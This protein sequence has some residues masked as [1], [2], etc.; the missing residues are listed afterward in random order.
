[1]DNMLTFFE[2]LSCFTSKCLHNNLLQ[3]KLKKRKIH[4]PP[5]MFVCLDTAC[6][7]QHSRQRFKMPPLIQMLSS[8]ECLRNN[9][10][11]LLCEIRE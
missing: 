1:M 2:I 11:L 8:F 9:L 10:L 7:E 3:Y 4:S 5:A 6:T